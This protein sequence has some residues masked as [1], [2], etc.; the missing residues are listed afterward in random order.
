MTQHAKL[1]GLDLHAPSNELVE[2]NSGSLISQ[3][4][5]VRL[6]GIG[7]AYPQV[8]LAN[9]TVSSNFGIVVADIPDTKSGF[10]TCA[11]FLFNVNT[12]TWT[13]GTILYSDA[14]GNLSTAI[15]GSPA[16]FVV[17]QDATFGV[18]YVTTLADAQVLQTAW[19]LF[20]NIIG[21]GEF[22]GTINAEAIRLRTNNVQRAVLDAQGRLGLGQTA[23]TRLFE[24]KSHASAGS[25]GAQI[26]S[27]HVDTSGVGFSP[28]YSVA[29][30]DPSLVRVEFIVTG[31]EVSGGNYASFK[32]T[33][34]FYR[35]SGN[36]QILDG[37][38]QS[39]HTQKTSKVMNV[40][41]SL[42]PT[43][44]TF[45]VK[46]DSSAVTRWGGYVIIQEVY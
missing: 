21:S 9:P 25:S 24:A 46:P 43:A 16:A 3:L 40:T 2:N 17:K 26:D 11:G 27:F 33:G 41:F 1:R 6:N 34:V 4:K 14:S 38:W 20:G 5:V 39:D 29:I 10:V 35:N 32:R 7:T 36:V 23:P 42:S 13:Q 12:S 31:R 30:T 44:V 19:G 45:Q 18:L 15:L 37:S 28:A 22:L 8:L